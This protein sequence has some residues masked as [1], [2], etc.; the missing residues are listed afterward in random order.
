MTPQG[1]LQVLIYNFFVLTLKMVT[2]DLEKLLLFA[3]IFKT[4]NYW[5]FLITSNLKPLY[6]VNKWA[7]VLSARRFS[8]PISKN[9]QEN[10]PW[11][12]RQKIHLLLYTQYQYSTTEVMLIV[13]WFF[14]PDFLE[15]VVEGE[16]RP[17]FKRKSLSD[18]EVKEMM[19]R[20]PKLHKNNENFFRGN[21]GYSVDHPRKIPES[22][23]QLLLA[24][25]SQFCIETPLLTLKRTHNA[26]G[27]LLA[28][29]VWIMMSPLNAKLATGCH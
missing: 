5:L 19:R 24:T 9:I 27:P 29:L 15:S 11:T 21:V 18:V 7:Q 22:I 17:R 10:F 6:F 26:L 3:T 14:F 1:T 25:C 2:I 23:F 4:F 16:P 20:M 12:F 13:C 28:F 8:N